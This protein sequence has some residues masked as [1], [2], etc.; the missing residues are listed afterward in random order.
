MSSY[1]G[2]RY[3]ETENSEWTSSIANRTG[4]LPVSTPYV[5]RIMPAYSV[6]SARTAMTFSNAATASPARMDSWMN[7]GMAL[8]STF[9]P[10]ILVLFTVDSVSSRPAAMFGWWYVCEAGS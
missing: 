7:A 5:V 2:E 3:V 1:D 9:I 10:A 6:C 4:N 8:P